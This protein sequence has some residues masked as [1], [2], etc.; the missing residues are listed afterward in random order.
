MAIVANT[1]TAYD[2]IGIR[3]QLSD[4]IYNI[5]PTQTP[6]LSM[7]KKGTASNILFEW[8]KDSLAAAAN[9]AQLEGDDVTAYTAVTPTVRVNNRTQIS[10]KTIVL[11][12]TEQAVTKAGRKDEMAYQV[13]LRG[14]ELKRDMET[15]LTQNS[16]AVTGSTTVARQTRGLEGW[17]GGTNSNLGATGV[18]ASPSTN[19]AATDGTQRAFTEAMLKDVQQKCFAAGGTPDTLMVGPTQKQVVSSFTGGSTRFDKS[20]D[21]KVYAAVS[22]YVG[23]FGEIKIIPNRFQRNRTAFLL[24]GDKFQVNYLRKFTVETLAKTGDADKRLLVCEY[25]LQSNEEAAS[26]AI[27]DLS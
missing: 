16:T 22:V 18:A 3:E 17:V 4:I 5:A 23:D 20:E 9:N 1:F 14:K 6:F 8:Q 12:A 26:G 2:A 25:G 21:A 19:T 15:S 27:R 24:E 10:R 13:M 7:C 11:S